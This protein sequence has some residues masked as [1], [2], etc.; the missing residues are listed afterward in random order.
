MPV[1]IDSCLDRET[2]VVTTRSSVYELI[3]LR[4]DGVVLVRGG[5]HF[6]EFRRALL[7]GAAAEG[8]P[9]DP[10]TIEIGLRMMF[11]LAGRLV[12][13]SAVESIFRPRV[14]AVSTE[15]AAVH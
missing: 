13:T 6:S 9:V 12:I 7:L 11:L 2:L 1:H 8:G 4:N 14:T 5:K 10:R 15:C 3:V